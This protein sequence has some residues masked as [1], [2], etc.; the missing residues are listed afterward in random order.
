[1]HDEIGGAA[2]LEGTDRLEVF[3]FQ[4]QIHRSAGAARHQRRAES[5]WGDVAARLVYP[6]QRIGHLFILN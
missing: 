4:V 5:Q 6:F 1:V 3:Q 2:D